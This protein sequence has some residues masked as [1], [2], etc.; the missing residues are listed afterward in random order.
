MRQQR[1][2][3]HHKAGA[4]DFTTVTPAHSSFDVSLGTGRHCV[5][6]KVDTQRGEHSGGRSIENLRPKGTRRTAEFVPTPSSNPKDQRNNTN[7]E[8]AARE[9]LR[10]LDTKGQLTAFNHWQRFCSIQH[11]PIDPKDLEDPEAAVLQFGAYLAQRED[12]NGGSIETYLNNLHSWFVSVGVRGGH[13]A[14]TRRMGKNIKKYKISDS[15]PRDPLTQDTLLKLLRDTTIADTY[16]KAAIALGWALGVRPA[17]LA[18]GIDPTLAVR[19]TDISKVSTESFNITIR[20]SKNSTQYGQ[21]RRCIS[22]F[23][24]PELDPVR[25]TRSLLQDALK[26]S[27]STL[28]PANLQGGIAKAMKHHGMTDGLILKGYSCRI[29]HVTHTLA[30]GAPAAVIMRGQGWGTEASMMRYERLNG[31]TS[32]MLSTILG[33]TNN[34]NKQPPPRD[35]GNNSKW[36]GG[37][38]RGAAP[39]SSQGGSPP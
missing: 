17:N 1:S 10:P 4:C 33:S 32:R 39:P 13:S 37:G 9:W 23:E 27:R 5:A 16:V 30:R 15:I 29:G 24:N 25:W 18:P 19:V 8:V 31:P 2:E 20:I 28:F 35:R 3:R 26:R 6:S 36:D 12:L 22:K 21:D 14:Q 7:Y 11:W 34:N 38:G